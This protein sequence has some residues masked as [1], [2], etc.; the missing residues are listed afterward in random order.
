MARPR[1]FR[2]LDSLPSGPELSFL[3]LGER[4]PGGWVRVD[5]QLASVATATAT[6]RTRRWGGLGIGLGVG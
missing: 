3:A 1:V 4:G 6:V 5:G 2:G